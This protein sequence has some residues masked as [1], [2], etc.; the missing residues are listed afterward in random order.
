MSVNGLK[1]A[2]GENVLTIRRELGQAGVLVS[3]DP[4][5]PRNIRLRQLIEEEKRYDTFQVIQIL[6]DLDQEEALDLELQPELEELEEIAPPRED[7]VAVI[8]WVGTQLTTFQI[9]RLRTVYNNLDPNVQHGATDVLAGVLCDRVILSDKSTD[10]QEMKKFMGGAEA[11]HQALD[12]ELSHAEATRQCVEILSQIAAH[13][14]V[15]RPTDACF[16]RPDLQRLP[17]TWSSYGETDND[18][19]IAPPLDPT[20]KIILLTIGHGAQGGY[21]SFPGRGL[22]SQPKIAE[23]LGGTSIKVTTLRIPLQC[24]PQ[25][26]VAEWPRKHGAV[27]IDSEERSDDNE[28]MIWIQ[29]DL[30]SAVRNWLDKL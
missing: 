26:A 16:I 13:V 23:L 29:N 28:M 24:F 5:S 3:P 14:L 30:A 11:V 17:N 10:N 8:I 25:Q 6:A 15:Y 12:Q 2:T 21:T 18:E 4:N 9:G 7:T 1:K 22:K 27:S 20:K 19:L